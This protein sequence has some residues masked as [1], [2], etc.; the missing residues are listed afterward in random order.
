M[1]AHATAYY[2]HALLLLLLCVTLLASHAATALP[3]VV[4]NTNIVYGQAVGYDGKTLDLLLDVYYLD[5]PQAKNRPVMV[6][7]H[8]GGFGG[9]DKAQELYIRMAQDF[10][11][12]GYVAFSINYRLR[13]RTTPSTVNALDGAVADATAAVEWIRQN[14]ARFNLDAENISLAGDSAGGAIVVHT[15]YRDPARI[16]ARVCLDLWG[17]LPTT[18]GN[19]SKYPW[20]D[21]LYPNALAPNTPPTCFIHGTGDVIVPYQ[22]SV[23]L[24]AKLA[25]AG[26]FFEFYPLTGANHYPQKLADQFIPIMIQF[27]N[28]FAYNVI[29]AAKK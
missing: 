29:P 21:T 25:A 18:P 15:C 26:V 17:G 11:R 3:P 13:D 7:V 20:A 12:A 23:D 6:L 28:T 1:P 9:G 8:G 22:S 24:A 4:A 19:P 14:S 10:A 16:R 5:E 2:R 27:T